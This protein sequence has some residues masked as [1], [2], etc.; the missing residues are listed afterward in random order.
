MIILLFGPLF[1]EF[2]RIRDLHVV[3]MQMNS[4]PLAPPLAQAVMQMWLV[5]ALFA[6]GGN[7]FKVTF[8]AQL[9]I[10]LSVPIHPASGKGAL[11]LAQ[12]NHRMLALPLALVAMMRELKRG[13][14]RR[15]FL[16]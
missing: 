15:H 4:A 16:P 11:E 12:L 10:I 2:R 14:G 6:I 1:R 5:P 13:R 3:L 7:M 8:H 9:A